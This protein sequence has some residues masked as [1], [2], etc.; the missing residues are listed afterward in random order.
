MP[1]DYRLCYTSIFQVAYSF[2]WGK[3]LSFHFIVRFETQ[4]G[5]ETVFREALLRVNTPT[6][7]EPGCLQIDVFESLFE[8]FV[9]AIHS[10]WI[11]EASFEVHAT[12]PHTVQFLEAA[13]TP[14][15]H[16][17]RGL[18]LHQIGGGPGAGRK[19]ITDPSM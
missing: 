18:R 8:P 12:S 4:P 19:L 13:E 9:F 11:D 17:V 5:E 15:T 2:G 7:P 16:P 3:A 10:Q 1:W 6:R 14:L